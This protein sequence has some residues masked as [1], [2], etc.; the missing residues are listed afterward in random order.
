M[1]AKKMVRKLSG[2][3]EWAMY[4]LNISIG[5]SH[6]CRY[7][8]AREFAGRFG[9]CESADWVHEKLTQNA[10]M[11]K[12]PARKGRVMFPSTHDITPGIL[13]DC[14]RVLRVILAAGN[15]V[16]I[17]TKPHLAVV[18]RLVKEFVKPDRR[19]MI[20]FRFTIGTLSPTLSKFWEPGAPLPS[21]RIDALKVAFEAGFNTSVSM[22]P[23]LGGFDTVSEVIA[24]VK[25][26]VTD[27]VWIGKMN[28]L[29]SVVDMDLVENKVLVAALEQKQTD[30]EIL[31]IYRK[32]KDNPMVK[33]KD[34]VVKVLT[35]YC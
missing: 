24:A 27:S 20:E 5:C 14:V 28:R 11:T 10:F 29:R 6:N 9:R 7:C 18:E 34:S 12:Y 19:E 1:A 31:K 25:D 17:V 15:D 30:T 8:Y 4:N 21:E 33:W 26:Y 13:D 35:K 32:F 16:L 23:M 3:K 2:T 22:E